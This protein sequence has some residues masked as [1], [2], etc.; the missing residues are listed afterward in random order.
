MAKMKIKQT[1]TGIQVIKMP[2]VTPSKPQGKYRS[3]VGG[4]KATMRHMGR[5]DPKAADPKDPGATPMPPTTVNWPTN[6][7]NAK[8]GY[9]VGRAW[10]ESNKTTGVHSDTVSVTAPH[11]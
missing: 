1:S 4:T 9:V 10:P 11:A 6:D 2:K 3:T 8:K 5:V 7:K